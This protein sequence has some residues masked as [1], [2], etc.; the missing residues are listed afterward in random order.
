M[1]KH[2]ALIKMKTI[3][4]QAILEVLFL[5]LFVVGI[6]LTTKHKCRCPNC[7]KYF[8]HY[9][10]D[11]NICPNCGGYINFKKRKSHGKIYNK[12]KLF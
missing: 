9:K 5:L 4:G 3:D 12:Y 8:Y 7:G 10:Y 11:G 1:I 6:L 2:Q